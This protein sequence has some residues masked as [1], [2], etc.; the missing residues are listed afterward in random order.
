MDVFSDFPRYHI[1]YSAQSPSVLSEDEL[2]ISA[3]SPLHNH[4]V[5]FIIII[6]LIKPRMTNTDVGLLWTICLPKHLIFST[7]LPCSCMREVHIFSQGG[8]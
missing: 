7:V 3:M 5:Y 8:K 1:L 6:T 4:T 2:L